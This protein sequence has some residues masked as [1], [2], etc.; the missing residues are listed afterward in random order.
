MYSIF[1]CKQFIWMGNVSKIVCRWLQ[2]EKN[3]LE[4][5]EDFLTYE[6]L[7]YECLFNHF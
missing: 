7:K 6:D 4:F 1:R 2:M 5:N 3:T